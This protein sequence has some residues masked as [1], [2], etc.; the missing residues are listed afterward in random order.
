MFAR[1][2]SR[3]SPPRATACRSSGIP[4]RM[5][6]RGRRVVITGAARG[7]GRALAARLVAEG[8]AVVVAD[9]DA[10]AAAATARDLGPAARAASLD[11]THAAEVEGLVAEV[12]QHDGPIDVWINNAGIMSLGAFLAQSPTRDAAQRAVNL[13]GVAS[14]MRAVLPRMLARR[15]GHI[16]NIASAAGRVGTPYAAMYS[17]TKFAVVGLTEAVRREHEGS[18][19]D[20]TVVLPSFVRTELIAGAGVPRWPPVATPED[21]AEAVLRALERGTPEVYVPRAARLAAVLPVV[22][23]RRLVE[24]VGRLLGVDR[25]FAEVDGPAR[26]AY[27]ARLERAPG[28]GEGPGGPSP[29][30]DEAA[31]G[32]AARR[33]R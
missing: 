19:V 11:V 28:V 20:F 24:G 23:P 12:E 15:R 2:P 26:A 33:E 3:P 4:D 29:T 31:V 5:R 17:A 8:A 32:P 21:V 6:Q 14:G 16:V 27:A 18:G 13:D 30:A 25:V 10:D 22:L 1:M 9:V 7:I